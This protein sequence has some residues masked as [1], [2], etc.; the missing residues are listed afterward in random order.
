MN[1]T[2]T[3]HLDTAEWASQ[4]LG[5]ERAR[6]GHA[7]P[8]DP[9]ASDYHAIAMAVQTL[10]RGAPPIDFSRQLM[11]RLA[12]PRAGIERRLL[13][14]L[15]VALAAVAAALVGMFGDYWWQLLSAAG[16]AL[17]WALPVAAC[18][19][20]SRLCRRWLGARSNVAPARAT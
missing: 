12:V 7:A 16:S 5:M 2:P 3:P 19:A 13:P 4:Q 15:L 6:R 18:I 14:G 9:A 1:T 20:A 11:Q 8:A 17:P 10:P